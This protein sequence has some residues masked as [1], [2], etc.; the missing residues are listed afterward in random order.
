[1]IFVSFVVKN[2]N[3]ENQ[4]QPCPV[5]DGEKVART[6]IYVERIG[7]WLQSGPQGPCG[8]CQGMGMVRSGTRRPEWTDNQERILQHQQRK[9]SQ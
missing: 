1:M 4:N 5:C 9:E 7:G 6:W 8:G 3:Q 2:M